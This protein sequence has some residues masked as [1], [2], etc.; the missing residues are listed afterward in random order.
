MELQIRLE[1]GI[2]EISEFATTIA[3]ITSQTNL[4]AL[5]AS[6]EA[7][8]A[9][10]MGKGFSVVAEEVKVLAENSK[11]ASDSIAGIL[12]NIGTLL[13]EVRVSNQENLDNIKEGIEKLHAAKEEA[14]NL[15]EL[16]EES[17]DKAQM[18]ATSSEDTVEHS[19]QVMQMVNQMQAL[20]QNTLSQANQIVQESEAQKG[21]SKE[22]EE[23]FL[24]V[25]DVSKSLLEIGR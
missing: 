21:V 19:R 9:C 24:Q 6:I 23:S 17:K 8:R 11:A 16:Q 3:K 25:N 7:A 22:V 4:L 18:V 14:G 2:A 12:Q 20:L 15:G 13:Q 10:E 5:N 1:S